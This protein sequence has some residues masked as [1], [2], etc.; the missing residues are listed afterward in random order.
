M[1]TGNAPLPYTATGRRII[2]QAGAMA[3]GTKKKRTGRP[4]G[5]V[6]RSVAAD[7]NVPWVTIIAVVAILAL[8]GGVFAYYWVNT[9]D[10]RAQEDRAEQARSFAPSA[11][12]PDPA[13][14]IPGVVV[15]N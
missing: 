7:K 15:K 3:S 11:S 14:D 12:N 13:K 1:L 10:Q 2:D 8:A 9:A 6:P 5:K 4:G